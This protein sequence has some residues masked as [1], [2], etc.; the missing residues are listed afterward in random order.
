V[1]HHCKCGVR[2]ENDTAAEEPVEGMSLLIVHM[3]DPVPSSSAPFSFNSNNHVQ[4]PVAGNS[5]IDFAQRGKECAGRD[6][7]VRPSPFGV[8]LRNEPGTTQQCTGLLPSA[9][10]SSET[11]TTLAP[12]LSHQMVLFP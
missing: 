6:E 1:L 10:Y 5:M 4:D 2:R 7:G 11:Q 9:R 3:Q 12:H 8:N